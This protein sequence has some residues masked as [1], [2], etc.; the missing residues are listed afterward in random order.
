MTTALKISLESIYAPIDA[1]LKRFG[2]RLKNELDS[3]DELIRA[4][5]EHILKMTGKFLRPALT[6][7]SSRIEGK[8]CA[9]SAIALGTAIELIHTATLV[10]D[11]IIDNSDFRRNQPSVHVRWGRDISII[12][13]DYLYAK[14]FLLLAGLND[15]FLS[16]AMAA[17]AHLMCEG[18]MKQVEKRKQFLM[19][20]EDYLKII[21][22]KTAALFQA[23]CMG[24]AY[25]SGTSKA[26]INKLGDYGLF[27]GMAFQ[28]VDD[29][30]DLVGESKTL[31]KSTGLDLTKNDVTLPLLYLLQ[32]LPASRREELLHRMRTTGG[33][34][35]FNEIKSLAIEEKAV[36]SA[37]S[38]AREY[39]DQALAALSGI[40]ETPLKESLNHLAHY[41][42][43]RAR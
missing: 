35:L 23:S 7:F 27:L 1:D 25:Y 10:H 4:I 6:I 43:D 18:E 30:L 19:N 22:Q 31:G 11:D 36:D 26:N 32:G 14:A 17:C 3:K 9:E 29:C 40:R 37:M 41:C 39:R 21:R 24:G 15:P 13:G 5:H 12:S 16:K 38:R 20:E 33:L 28:I 2:T 42:I 8:P 34:E